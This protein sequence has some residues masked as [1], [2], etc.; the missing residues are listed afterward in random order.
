MLLSRDIHVAR[1]L[2]S[3]LGGHLPSIPGTG[4]GNFDTARP[5]NG[6]TRV[7]VDWLLRF[8]CQSK[9]KNKEGVACWIS[10][11]QSL[12]VRFSLLRKGHLPTGKGLLK[13]NEK[14]VTPW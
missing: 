9:T 2:E 12:A 5:N 4:R 6:K 3:G 7:S 10:R 13:A 8:I 1:S 11:W 14:E